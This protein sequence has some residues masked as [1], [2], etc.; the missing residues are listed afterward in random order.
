MLDWSTPLAHFNRRGP[1]KA[2]DLM[3]PNPHV[4]TEDEPL[5]H[6]A[7]LMRVHHIGC[8][9]VVDDRHRLHLTGVITDRDIVVRCVAERHFRDCRVS[10]HMTTDHLDT[11]SPEASVS[12][13]MMLMQR[14][15]LRRILVT[16]DGRL[17]GIIAQADLAL[18]EGP[19]NPFAVEEVLERVSAPSMTLR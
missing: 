5:S 1:M 7:R 15:Q 2:R 10:D 8:I 3:T 12:T 4:V 13:V 19:L 6:A 17:V 11:V 14:D 18:K 16:E 9:P